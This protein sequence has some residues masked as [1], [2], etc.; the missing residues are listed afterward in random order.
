VNYIEKEQDILRN[1]TPD[2]HKE[3]CQ[4][5]IKPD[6]MFYVIVGDA[7]TQLKP[8]KELGFGEPILIKVD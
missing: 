6:Q 1:M 2:Q 4:K 5:Y 8:L 3:L 7:A